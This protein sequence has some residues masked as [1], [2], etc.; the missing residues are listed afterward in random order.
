M[1][2]AGVFAITPTTY[3]MSED[4]VLPTLLHASKM[5]LLS[6][7]RAHPLTFDSIL[8]VVA[9][10][11]APEFLRV[12]ATLSNYRNMPAQ[13]SNGH[14]EDATDKH[15]ML[16]LLSLDDLVAA[17][18]PKAKDPAPPTQPAAE[19]SGARG[20]VRSS[21]G[22]SRLWQAGS[23]HVIKSAPKGQDYQWRMTI[24]PPA[25]SGGEFFGMVLSW[26]GDRIFQH[27]ALVKASTTEDLGVCHQLLRILGGRRG[28][29]PPRVERN[30]FHGVLTGTT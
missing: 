20:V 22:E 24:A 3:Y 4:E 17:A 14:S 10:A 27:A 7:L 18:G 5:R 9:D 29:N 13:R 23:L 2:G 8:R 28:L 19:G 16:W 15:K 11:D 12:V 6:T 25:Q 30:V 21:L 26:C 1:R